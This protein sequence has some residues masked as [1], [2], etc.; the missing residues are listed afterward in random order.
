[1]T[2]EAMTNQDIVEMVIETAGGM[3]PLARALGI[4]FQSIQKWKKIPAER[5]AAVE[6]VTGISREDLRPDIFGRI[7]GATAVV[8][9]KGPSRPSPRRPARK[10]K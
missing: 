10:K 1:M 4:K 5:V 3:G 2:L 7:P 6:E 8:E 9:A